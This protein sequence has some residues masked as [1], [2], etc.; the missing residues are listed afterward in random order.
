MLLFRPYKTKLKHRL[1]N[2][3]LDVRAILRDLSVLFLLLIFSSLIFTATSYTLKFVLDAKFISIAPELLLILSFNLFFPLVFFTSLSS[4]LSNLY[5]SEDIELLLSSPLSPLKLFLQKTLVVGIESSWMA[6]ISITPFL[7]GFGASYGASP[8]YYILM[9]LF[10]ALFVLIPSAIA[11][12]IS[13]VWGLVVPRIPPLALISTI[14]G[15]GIFI[16]HKILGILGSYLAG[17]ANKGD[18]LIFSAIDKYSDFGESWSPATWLAKSL[19]P[20]LYT[21]A[22]NGTLELG[23]ETISRFICGLGAGSSSLILFLSIGYILSLHLYSKSLSSMWGKGSKVL[24]LELKLP[25]LLSK[26]FPCPRAFKQEFSMFKKEALEFFRDS[27]QIVQTLF[28]LSIMGI[29]LYILNYQHSIEP[30]MKGISPEGWRGILLLINITL[31]CFISIAMATRLVFPSLSREGRAIWII[32]TCPLELSKFVYTK[33]IFWCIPIVILMSLLST[34]SQYFIYQMISVSIAKLVL[35]I[36]SVLSLNALALFLGARFSEF[37]WESRS[38]LVASLGSLI[39]MLSGLLLIGFNLG[40]ST[41][42][43]NSIAQNSPYIIQF[44]V[45]IIFLASIN[46]ALSVAFLRLAS[47]SLKKKLAQEVG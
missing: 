37:D 17:D 25:T 40:V 3:R 15:I 34:I 29:Y 38:Q 14:G 35:T 28:L 32:Q 2:Y 12:I 36:T 8:L 13:I 5:Q 27:T 30:F 22:D 18:A 43:I 1:E 23:I 19:S 21:P 7:L 24:S 6:I 20:F 10:L 46:I 45:L 33:Y 41:T 26:K 9:P 42:I 11:M 47:S 39:F 44:Y 31:E 16:L 4:A